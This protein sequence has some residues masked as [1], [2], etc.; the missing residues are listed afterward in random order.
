MVKE[1][2]RFSRV[3]FATKTQLI[4][5]GKALLV[6]RIINLSVGGCQVEM[7]EQLTSGMECEMQI[8]LNTENTLPD[9][10]VSGKVL[11]LE[12]AKTSIQHTSID[13]D[14]LYHLQNIVRYNSK[15]PDVIEKEIG[16][17]PGIV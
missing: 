17:H 15:D 12:G 1:H 2:R 8:F 6:K 10:R 3:S 16:L 14:S 7:D 13:P 11:R 5:Q 4:V 9:I